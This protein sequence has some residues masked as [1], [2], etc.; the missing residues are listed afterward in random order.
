M[1]HNNLLILL[2]MLAC[3]FP[4]RVGYLARPIRVNWL[5]L[6]VALGG[7]QTTY[8]N[9]FSDP[10][11]YNNERQSKMKNWCVTIIIYVIDNAHTTGKVT[12]TDSSG[13][14]NS[15]STRTTSLTRTSFPV[16]IKLICYVID[17]IV[18]YVLA[19][20]L[21]HIGSILMVMYM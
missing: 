4:H 3:C 10:I 12:C 21:S 13:D 17:S 18:R 19:A 20:S 15:L 16:P 6:L 14:W 11:V 7:S 5:W 9:F 1:P 2:M 8:W